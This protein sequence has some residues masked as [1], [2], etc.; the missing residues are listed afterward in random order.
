MSQKRTF[1]LKQGCGYLNGGIQVAAAQCLLILGTLL[2]ENYS[3]FD[4][5][6][7]V[8]ANEMNGKGA[9]SR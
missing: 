5:I 3:D 9:F 7:L 6:G 8:V 2:F 1:F 4:F